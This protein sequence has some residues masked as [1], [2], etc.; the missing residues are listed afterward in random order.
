MISML[1][2]GSI[3]LKEIGY[4]VFVALNYF[5]IDLPILK[6]EQLPNYQWHMPIIVEF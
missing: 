4:L 2:I 5:M 3:L 6:A 1:D